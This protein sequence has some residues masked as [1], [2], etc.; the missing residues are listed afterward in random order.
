M[1]IKRPGCTYAVRRTFYDRLETIWNDEMAHDAIL[2]RC[3][4]LQGKAYSVDKNLI[5]WRRHKGASSLKS[6]FIS[7]ENYRQDRIR[8][9]IELST[10]RIEFLNAAL[11][12]IQLYDNY[13]SDNIVKLLQK[14]KEFEKEHIKVF[15]QESLVQLIK[16]CIKYNKFYLS[17]RTQLGE[18]KLLLTK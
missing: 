17:H 6:S 1:Y 8:Y 7:K 4:I 9:G 2:W 10:K 11:R 3:A 14:N 16:V 13:S 15:E 18:F 12:W 5:Y